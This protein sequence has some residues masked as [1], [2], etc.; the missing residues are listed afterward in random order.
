MSNIAF[1]AYNNMSVIRITSLETYIY[2]F[3]NCFAK[4]L[5]RLSLAHIIIK[6]LYSAS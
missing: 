6:S 3:N 1:L 2:I 5:L 4:N